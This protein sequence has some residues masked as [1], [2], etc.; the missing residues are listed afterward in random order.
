MEPQALLP[1]Q[2]LVFA[3]DCVVNHH[4]LAIRVCCP[5]WRTVSLYNISISVCAMVDGRTVPLKLWHGVEHW[6]VWIGAALPLTVR[7]D[8]SDEGSPFN[9]NSKLGPV[10]VVTVHVSAEDQ[11]GNRISQGYQYLNPDSSV[12]RGFG[13]YADTGGAR[14]PRYVV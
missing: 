8:V 5:R 7:H 10:A 13:K 1:I 4:E 2:Q 11:D 3:P 14:F 9:P 12:F 6:P